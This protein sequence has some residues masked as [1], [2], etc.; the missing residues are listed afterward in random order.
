MLDL[1]PLATLTEEKVLP[2]ENVERR[3]ILVK[4]ARS[5][6]ATIAIDMPLDILFETVQLLTFPIKSTTMI[7][8]S[9]ITLMENVEH[10]VSTM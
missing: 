8:L 5:T 7:T 2:A 3:A 10:S 4:N 9:K 1:V 6:I